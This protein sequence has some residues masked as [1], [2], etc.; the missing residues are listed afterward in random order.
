[1]RVRRGE[2]GRGREGGGPRI[3]SGLLV[4]SRDPDA[5]P[6][7]MNPEIKT[8]VEVRGLTD[9]ATQAPLSHRMFKLHFESNSL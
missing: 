9:R 3:R 6:E 7:L 2:L 5:G 4:D 1:M 8:R